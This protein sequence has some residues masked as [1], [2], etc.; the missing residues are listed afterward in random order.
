MSRQSSSFCLNFANCSPAI[1]ME[2][3]VA[4]KVHVNDKIIAWN[5]S[6][7]FESF[8]PLNNDVTEG[9]ITTQSK[10]MKFR[11]TK[12][13]IWDKQILVC[14]LIIIFEVA[15]RRDPLWKTVRLNS[16]QKPQFQ[17]ISVFFSFAHPWNL[18]YLLC[19]FNLPL[20]FEAVIFMFLSI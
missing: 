10:R 19:Y 13:E 8:S 20:M 4:K 6:E 12:S 15:N 17:S 16:C 5:S 11:L 2:L 14:L 9:V 18:L 7:C 1:T 3:N